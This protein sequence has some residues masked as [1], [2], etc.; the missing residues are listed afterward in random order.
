MV[1]HATL[2]YCQSLGREQIT[3]DDAETF[4]H[5]S[6]VVEPGAQIGAGTRIWHFCHVMAGARIGV[7]C[8]FGQ[9]CFVAGGVIVGDRA[10]I[11][12]NVSLYAGVELEDE[13]FVG[14]SVVFTN[15]IRPRAM[16]SRR[17][18]FRRTRVGRG[19]TLGAN[20]TIL[21]GIT[22]SEYCLVG[23]GAVISGDVPAFALMLGVPAR[24]SGWVSRHGEPLEFG[25]DGAARCPA[26]GER[27]RKTLDRVEW[28]N[29]V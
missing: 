17:H 22:L 20:A 4:I 21:P 29:S 11:Q 24:L 25:S 14:P 26:T 5:P 12:N 10:R 6:A 3:V 2:H 16:V 18:E 8:S 7:L 13:V 15:V 1:L 23:A 27:Y 9:N 28:L 19:A